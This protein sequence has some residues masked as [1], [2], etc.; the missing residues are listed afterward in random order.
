M[1]FCRY[2]IGAESIVGKPNIKFAVNKL[3]GQKVV[4]KFCSEQLFD[5]AR[6][7]NQQLSHQFV[8][9]SV[10]NGLSFLTL[11]S[12]IESR[13]LDVIRDPKGYP[14]CFVFERGEETLYEWMQKPPTDP[15]TRKDVLF[16][17]ELCIPLLTTH[18]CFRF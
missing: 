9:K 14:P 11:L 3:S 15:F 12:I 8:C 16:Q 17:V 6:E 1:L 13:P 4:L 18:L 7:L 5:K 2:F 10:K